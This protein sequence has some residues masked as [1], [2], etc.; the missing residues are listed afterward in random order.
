M[1]VLI[2]LASF[3][4]SRVKP[5]G[6]TTSNDTFQAWCPSNVDPAGTV[7]PTIDNHAGGV[8]TAN[9]NV[10]ILAA[11]VTRTY[12]YLRNLHP[13]DTMWLAYDDVANI[14][15]K[16]TKIKADEAYEIDGLSPV[17]VRSETGNRITVDVDLGQG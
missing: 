16:G 5:R 10:R 14:F 11:D 1:T 4:N 9:G 6:A 8:V 17:Y 13:T 15:T 12:G 2:A 7:M 3:P